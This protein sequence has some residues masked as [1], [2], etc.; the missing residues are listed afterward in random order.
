MPQPAHAPRHEF[1]APLPS[2]RR[3]V[4]RLPSPSG[5]AS[6]TPL[7]PE[8]RYAWPARIRDVSAHGVGLLLSRCLYEGSV[9][10]LTLQNPA[11][12]FARTVLAKVVRVAKA[13]GGGWVVGCA[14][15]EKLADLELAAML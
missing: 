10:E 11:K 1:R 8:E 15:L 12:G 13:E 5:I 2:E 3:A 7:A 6:K 9:F 14:F 4:L